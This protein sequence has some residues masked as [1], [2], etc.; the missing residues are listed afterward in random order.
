MGVSGTLTTNKGVN[1]GPGDARPLS[2]CPENPGPHIE[3][4]IGMASQSRVV[5]RAPAR[6]QASPAGRNPVAT[7]CGGA[8]PPRRTTTKILR[9][10]LVVPWRGRLP[11]E[12]EV[13]G[14]IP[15]EGA[16]SQDTRVV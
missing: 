15:V 14:S 5:E 3:N 4:R 1:K 10:A 12:Q 16:M 11:V 13:A 7:G 9:R 2:F 6:A 8:N